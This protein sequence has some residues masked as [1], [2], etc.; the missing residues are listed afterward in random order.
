[1]AG[2]DFWGQKRS[3]EDRGGVRGEKIRLRGEEE[4]WMR[5]RKRGADTE[6]AS[7]EKGQ[8]RQRVRARE[9]IKN[10][11]KRWKSMPCSFTGEELPPWCCCFQFDTLM[12]KSW[13]PLLAL[14]ALTNHCLTVQLE[15]V[16]LSAPG[17]TRT[18]NLHSFSA[19]RKLCCDPRKRSMDKA[20]PLS[21]YT[22]PPHHHPPPHL[23]WK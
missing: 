2:F 8:R 17:F 13:K 19:Q 21:I 15:R 5:R 6:T 20:S 10:R 18:L 3:E 9:K 23:F 16:S 14:H 7:V 4:G 11:R 1:M 22:Q 12:I